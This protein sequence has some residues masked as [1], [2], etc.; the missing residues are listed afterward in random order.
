MKTKVLFLLVFL[1]ASIACSA[2]RVLNDDEKEQLVGHTLF[3]Q[4]CKWAI[5]DYSSYWY[6]HDGTGLNTSDRAKWRREYQT[7]KSVN[8]A[9]YEDPH[10]TLRFLIL[11]KG[12]S[13]SVDADPTSEEIIAL[14]VSG[15]KFEELASLYMTLVTTN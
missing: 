2:Q 5:R 6:A 12:M 3:I 8:A 7:V 1:V 9:E 15:N 11:A 10:L 14:F 13:F 4:K